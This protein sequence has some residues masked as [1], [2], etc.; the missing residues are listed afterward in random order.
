MIVRLKK[1]EAVSDGEHG[2]RVWLE[3]WRRWILRL[4]TGAAFG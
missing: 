1:I 4:K 2:F 3:R